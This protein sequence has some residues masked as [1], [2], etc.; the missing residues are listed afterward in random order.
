MADET[1]KFKKNGL[2]DFV[3]CFF[4]IRHAYLT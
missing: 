4:P 2:V 1:M 3:F